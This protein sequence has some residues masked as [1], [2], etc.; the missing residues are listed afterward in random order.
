[1]RTS[2]QESEGG[3]RKRTNENEGANQNQNSNSAIRTTDR[4][5]S[6]R[7][8]LPAR[9]Y[10]TSFIQ[11]SCS[12]RS[13]ENQTT[14]RRAN[15]IVTVTAGTAIGEQL[16]FAAKEISDQCFVSANK[17]GRRSRFR[18]QSRSLS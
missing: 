12:T 10:S 17:S 8:K 13:K 16:V 9:F 15:L 1:M 7:L 11:S 3:K 18:F 5:A 4:I 2:K 6:V 14:T